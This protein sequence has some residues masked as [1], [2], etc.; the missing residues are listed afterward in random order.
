MVEK[1]DNMVVEK[2]DNMASFQATV[3]K[4]EQ[5]LDDLDHMDGVKEETWNITE[6]GGAEARWGA[7]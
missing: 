1:V 2:V 7:S 3:N 6:Q 5:F 4:L